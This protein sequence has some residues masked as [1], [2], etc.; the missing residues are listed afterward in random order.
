ML[1]LMNLIGRLLYGS[2]AVDKAAR[3]S[4]KIKARRRR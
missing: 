1:F 3:S 4:G 2:E